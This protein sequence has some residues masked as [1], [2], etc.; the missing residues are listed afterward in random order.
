MVMDIVKKNLVS[1]LC[2]VVAIICVV[3]IF[4][5]FGGMYAS[6][7]AEVTKSHGI[8]NSLDSV[9]RA[10]RSWPTLSPREEDKVP[11]KNFPTASA[12]EI[13]KRQT[14][15]WTHDTQEFLV[16]A[17]KLQDAQLHLLVPGSLPGNP[18]QQTIAYEFMDRYKRAFGL[19]KTG[20]G[21]AAGGPVD[22]AL[23]FS[24]PAAIFNTIIKAKLPP[25][26][27]E[28]KLRQDEA[29]AQIRAR[30]TKTNDKGEITNAETVNTEVQKARESTGVQT[31]L[32]RAREAT[33]YLDPVQVFK[34]DPKMNVNTAPSPNDMF[35][36]QIGLWIQ[37]EIC[38][39]IKQTN[40]GAKS[41]VIDAPVKRVLDLK[42]TSPYYAVTGPPTPPPEA[43]QNE[44]NKLT[45]DYGKNPLGHV[46]G[47]FY[48]VIP[49]QINLICD[50]D[51]LPEALTGLTAN[52]YMMCRRVEVV[53]VDSALAFAQGYLYGSRPV[54]Q[55]NIEA[56]YLLLR[57]FIAPKMPPDIIRGLTTPPKPGQPY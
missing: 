4:F 7:T 9:K 8:G 42:F 17:V 40:A 36:A 53:S 34:P 22:P 6:L 27:A 14:D 5:P 32:T 30:F 2:G 56:Q 50:A 15:G 23:I 33:V 47:E 37:Q 16:A 49:F 46:S 25:T 1:I 48:D 10:P 45:L 52:R 31:R 3:L 35:E 21:P 39:A 43:P 57:K 29:E 13:A 26:E 11:L 24:Q 54:V 20:V 51:R 18:G 44:A 12:V 55:V 19:L 28:I 38:E 41:G